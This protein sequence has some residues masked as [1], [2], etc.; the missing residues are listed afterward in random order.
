M[1]ASL[2]FFST[3]TH[4]SAV[5]GASTIASTPWVTKLFSACTCFSWLPCASTFFSVTPRLGASASND[6]VSAVRQ[7]LSAPI[8]ENPTVIALPEPFAPADCVV[9]AVLAP[10]EDDDEELSPGSQAP[11]G[12]QNRAGSGAGGGVSLRGMVGAFLLKFEVENGRQSICTGRVGK[13]R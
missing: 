4:P 5:L 7:A 12:R 2:I 10:P 8:C 11:R 13:M 6:L 9:D 1:F 3:G